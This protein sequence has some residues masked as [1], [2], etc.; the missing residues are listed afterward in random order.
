MNDDIRMQYL[1]FVANVP[2][3]SMIVKEP[4]YYLGCMKEI[5][6]QLDR[7][8]EL[9]ESYLNRAI[10][11]QENADVTIDNRRMLV[12]ENAILELMDISE[13][14]DDDDLDYLYKLTENTQFNHLKVKLLEGKEE[15]V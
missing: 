7:F 1:F 15:Y 13:P 8:I 14:I 9:N 4:K 3:R 11:K 2:A 10:A 5:L 6:T 12:S